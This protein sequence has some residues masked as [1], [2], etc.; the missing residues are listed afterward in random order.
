MPGVGTK[1]QQSSRTDDPVAVEGLL[2][3]PDAVLGEFGQICV[4]LPASGAVIAVR[5]LAGLRCTVSFGN[6]PV[7]GSYLPMDS[8]F[9]AKCM[10]TGEIVLCED[11]TIN[12]GNESVPAA[13]AES[14]TFRSA[15]TVPVKF[16]GGVMGVIQMFST[17][18]FA[19]DAATIANLQ[20]VAKSFATL[21]IAD[22]AG[23]PSPIGDNPLTRDPVPLNVPTVVG[24]SDLSR[25]SLD[26]DLAVP[27]GDLAEESPAVT[28][29]PRPPS[30][31]AT[32]APSEPEV[33]RTSVIGALAEMAQ[34]IRARAA[35]RAA[36][37]HLPSDK[38]TPTRVW[39]ITA[40]LLL[41]LSLL[42]LLLF[43]AAHHAQSE[44][45]ENT[46]AATRAMRA[47][48]KKVSVPMSSNIAHSL[49]EVCLFSTC[50]NLRPS[51][52]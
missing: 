27:S 51:T 29:S 2:A 24:D 9:I 17:Q 18:P 22:A 30:L 19:I 4:G 40:A 45:S 32:Q 5:D 50:Q 16:K 10:Q 44:S 43:K 46:S 33:N 48:D 42:I 8:A 23:D 6:A 3:T 47:V 31:E 37:L 21:I 15:V 39:L 35:A 20:V 52:G 36:L 28:N 25:G 1:Q 26:V 7:V 12:E 38:P 49:R 13:G 14:S 41:V 34:A 11:T